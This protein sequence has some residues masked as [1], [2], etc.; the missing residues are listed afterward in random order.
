MKYLIIRQKSF[1]CAPWWQVKKHDVIYIYYSWYLPMTKF[2]F[3]A[4]PTMMSLYRHI[5]LYFN[6]VRIAKFYLCNF[7]S[8]IRQQICTMERYISWGY[9]II[10]RRG[11]AINQSIKNKIVS[12]S[13]RVP[14]WGNRKKRLQKKSVWSSRQR[15]CRLYN[16]NNNNNIAC[17]FNVVISVEEGKKYE[18]NKRLVKNVCSTR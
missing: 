16:N 11:F 2:G 9:Y 4:K 13:R 7:R 10:H 18:N 14:G 12:C 6:T 3:D 15:C 5:M 8:S 1:F 17:I